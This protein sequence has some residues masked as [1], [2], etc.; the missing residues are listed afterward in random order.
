[1]ALS[2]DMLNENSEKT[3]KCKIEWIVTKIIKLNNENCSIKNLIYIKSEKNTYFMKWFFP[4]E[5][6]IFDS[7]YKV[8]FYNEI[9]IWEKVTFY[10]D[11][12]NYYPLDFDTR[13]TNTTNIPYCTWN[14]IN[15]QKT[16]PIAQNYS[17]YF[18]SWSL[19]LSFIIILVLAFKLLKIKK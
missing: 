9:K 3:Q 16:E 5:G 19:I 18:L 12:N 6:C 15:T 14:I 4:N 8:F 1:M 2:P 17:N 11:K 13:V 10:L 7:F